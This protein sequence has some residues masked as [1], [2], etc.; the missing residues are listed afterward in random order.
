M[1]LCQAKTEKA[2]DSSCTLGVGGGRAPRP[3]GDQHELQAAVGGSIAVIME[4]V[5]VCFPPIVC[6]YMLHPCSLWAGKWVGQFSPLCY[7]MGI[8]P[9]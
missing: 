3:A 2:Q 9:L 4:W 7:R 8:R 1:Q 6:S 5:C